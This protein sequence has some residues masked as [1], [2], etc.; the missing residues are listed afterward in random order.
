[1]G[2]TKRLLLISVLVFLGCAKD[3][4]LDDYNREKALDDLAQFQAAEGRYSGTITLKDGSIIGGLEL[5]ITARLSS[6]GSSTAPGTQ[7]GGN[8]D[9]ATLLTELHFSDPRFYASLPSQNGFFDP[10]SGVY[11]TQFMIQE[12]NASTGAVQQTDVLSITGNIGGG[13]VKG[14]L[15]GVGY[16]QNAGYFD[17][18]INGPDIQD[19]GKLGKP[20]AANSSEGKTLI[21]KSNQRSDPGDPP[22]QLTA[23]YPVVTAVD[24]LVHIFLPDTN[25][26]LEVDVQFSPDV[27]VPFPSA[28]WDVTSGTLTANNNT[29]SQP[30]TPWVPQLRCSNFYFAQTNSKFTCDYWS[31]RTS[32][33]HI[34]FNPATP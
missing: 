18:V 27:D 19:L 26:T 11:Q 28:S 15:L 9:A 3:R 21:Y 29:V 24:H 2:M 23:Y 10:D 5:V 30:G 16:Q 7:Q 4:T 1:M 31:N 22:I 13:H 33:Q 20:T 6:Q 14:S 12:L 8:N 25:Q 34:T 17:L 32:V